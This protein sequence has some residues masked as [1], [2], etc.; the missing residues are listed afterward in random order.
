[1]Y[2]TVMFADDNS[3]DEV[4]CNSNKAPS[5]FARGP[6]LPLASH[7]ELSGHHTGVANMP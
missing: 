7:F 2:A 6:V 3:V 5:D 1:M 4:N